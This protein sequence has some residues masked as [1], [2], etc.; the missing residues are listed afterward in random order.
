MLSSKIT[1]K[2]YVHSS[3]NID[4]NTGWNGS[5][6]SQQCIC[7]GKMGN[8]LISNLTHH[9]FIIIAICIS[10]G[11]SMRFMFIKSKRRNWFPSIRNW[12]EKK[13]QK[14]KRKKKLVGSAFPLTLQFICPMINNIDLDS[15]RNSVSLFK[16]ERNNTELCRFL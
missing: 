12:S 8:W 5:I 6:C 1:V 14:L 9:L 15:L 7:N 2:S 3:I 11:R 13:Q 10:R 16:E 4:V